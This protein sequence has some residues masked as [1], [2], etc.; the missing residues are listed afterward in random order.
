MAI[1][2]S[3]ILFFLFTSLCVQCQQWLPLQPS[4]CFT[5]KTL[6]GCNAIKLAV[7]VISFCIDGMAMEASEGFQRAGILCIGGFAGSSF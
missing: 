6:Q 7:M 5:Q 1:K 3:A 2:L 4:G